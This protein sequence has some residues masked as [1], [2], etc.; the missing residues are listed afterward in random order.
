M[1]GVFKE[2]SNQTISPGICSIHIKHTQSWT[3]ETNTCEELKLEVSTTINLALDIVLEDKL[4]KF[5]V[6]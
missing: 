2:Q 4:S 1:K 3:A 5:V 6:L